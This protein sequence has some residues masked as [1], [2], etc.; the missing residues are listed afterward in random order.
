H[1]ISFNDDKSRATLEYKI[2]EG[3]RYKIRNVEVLGNNIFSEEQ[4]RAHMALTEGQY[5]NTRLLNKD[6]DKIQDQYGQLGR[7]FATVDAIPRFLETPGEADLVYRI[8]EDKV[9]RVRRVD[10]VINGDHPHTRRAV[11]LNSSLIHPGDLANP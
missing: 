6:I 1:D 3:P 11:V 5:F 8:D 9:Y 2:V 7:L 10:V 4:L